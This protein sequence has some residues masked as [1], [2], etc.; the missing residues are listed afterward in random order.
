VSADIVQRL[1]QAT[2]SSLPPLR[3][4]GEAADEIQRL[5]REVID[6]QFRLDRARGNYD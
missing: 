4:Y 3:L 1:R 5:R 6:L 2:R